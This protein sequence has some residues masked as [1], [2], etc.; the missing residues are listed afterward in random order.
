MLISDGVDH[1]DL[2]LCKSNNN[3]YIYIYHPFFLLLKLPQNKKQDWCGTSVF[4]S[5]GHN[6]ILNCGN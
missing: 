2:L 5:V 4:F 3:I 1:Y 6:W